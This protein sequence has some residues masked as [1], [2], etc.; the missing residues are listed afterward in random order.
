MSKVGKFIKTEII[1]P[2]TLIYLTH[3]ENFHSSSRKFGDK[4]LVSTLKANRETNKEI[5]KKKGAI[6]T[7][8][9]SL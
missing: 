7:F 9:E 4:L 1:Y 8:N 3:R 2:N 6:I 5:E